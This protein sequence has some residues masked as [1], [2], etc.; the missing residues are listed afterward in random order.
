MAKSTKKKTKTKTRGKGT[1]SITMTASGKYKV[2][3]K[4]TDVYGNRQSLTK[5]VATEDLAHRQL[6]KF[7]QEKARAEKAPTE[8]VRKYTVEEYFKKIWLP[9]KMTTLNKS[10]SYRRIESTVDTHIIP[11]IGNKIWSQVNAKDINNILQKS[12]NSGLAHSSIKKIYDA[13]SGMYKYA[14]DVRMDISR[15]ENPMPGVNM[16]SIKKFE[17]TEI[18]WFKPEELPAFVTECLRKNNAD[19]DV[20]I[21]GDSYLFM[22][23]TGLRMGEFSGLRKSDFDFENKLL[24]VNKSVQNEITKDKFGGN[25]YCLKVDDPKTMN[26]I[27]YVPLSEEAIFYAKRIMERFPDGDMFVYSNKGTLVRPE[28]LSKQYKRILRGAELEERGLHAL[29]HTFVSVLFENGVDT[30]TIAEIIGDM[31]DTVK[32]TYLHLYKSRKAKAVEGLNIVAN[33]ASCLQ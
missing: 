9:Y 18:Q 22:L 3:L 13:F 27:R 21:H 4:Y 24:K 10:Q 1:G 14:T 19:Q 11:A 2:V 12:Y 33:A 20:H 5:T 30:K 31:E 16:I 17:K 6:E 29:R 26:S 23:N 8:N 15:E 25:H 32:K 7:K 28:T